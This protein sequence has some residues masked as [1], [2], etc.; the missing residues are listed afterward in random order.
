MVGVSWQL[1]LFPDLETASQSECLPQISQEGRIHDV[2]WGSS[3][4]VIPITGLG[5]PV[6]PIFTTITNNNVAYIVQSTICLVLEESVYTLYY[7][8]DIYLHVYTHILKNNSST[9]S[10]D[11]S[12]HS[13]ATAVCYAVCPWIKNSSSLHCQHFPL[14][15]LSC[16]DCH[17]PGL[18]KRMHWPVSP[19]QMCWP[20]Y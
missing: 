18:I 20:G 16:A 12:M 2:T 10:S 7:I 13:T 6:D 14:R 11:V 3:Y 8:Y 4:P 9:E 1:E 5:T 15:H 19:C 17:W